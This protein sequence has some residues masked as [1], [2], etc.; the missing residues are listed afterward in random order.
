[1]ATSTADTTTPAARPSL[2]EALL[3]GLDDE[4]LH[5]LDSILSQTAGPPP[6]P[7]AGPAPVPEQGLGQQI[8]GGFSGLEHLNEPMAHGFGASLVQGLGRGLG[9]A[10]SRVQQQRAQL[11]AMHQRQQERTDT[12]NQQA[13]AAYRAEQGKTRGQ[14]V[15]DVLKENMTQLNKET[16]EQEARRKGLV[17]GAEAS[18][19]AA[20][21][22][23]DDRWTPP[24]RRG[25]MIMFTSG[26]GIPPF[27]RGKNGNANR[28]QFLNDL[29]AMTQH[30]LDPATAANISKAERANATK[31]ATWKGANDTYAS[32]VEKNMQ[33]V[34][35]YVDKIANLGSSW[36]NKPLRDGAYAV[37]DK[38][39]AGY[40]AA[41]GAAAPEVARLLTA[42]PQTGGGAL[43]DD[44]RHEIATRIVDRNAT[45]DQIREAFKVI[46]A[47]KANRTQSIDDSIKESRD[48][49][50]VL[51][52][53]G[54]DFLGGTQAGPPR[55]NT[56]PVATHRYNPTTG[57]VE[58]IGAP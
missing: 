2:V 17:A 53:T 42:A 5:A 57:R 35:G 52:R 27:A 56:A 24:E 33:Q 49:L 16:P 12:A 44:A 39:L 54:Y 28:K 37:G 29:D 18:A 9:S 41:I 11:E 31:L 3:N 25:A 38:N 21:E 55:G 13:T 19:K 4:H 58:Q 1:M 47:D 46:R 45:P 23:D 51:G 15:S 30:G 26:N 36:L 43:S 22:P 32:N 40:N 8:V 6:A 20:N 34:E 7:E 50:N 14:V 48:R 10:G